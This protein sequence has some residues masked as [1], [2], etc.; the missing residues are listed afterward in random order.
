[1]NGNAIWPKD[2]K[3]VDIVASCDHMG[4]K[5]FVLGFRKYQNEESDVVEAQIVRK[6]IELATQL[7]FEKVS[8]KE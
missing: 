1:M 6:V 8:I 3:A 2:G 7:N 4:E 5:T